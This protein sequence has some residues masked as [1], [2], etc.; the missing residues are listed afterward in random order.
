VLALPPLLAYGVALR[1]GPLYYLL[2]TVTVLGAPLLPAAVG[3]VLVLLAARL[4]P[5]RRGREVLGLVAALV[6]VSCSL[7]GQ[8]SRLW[9]ERLRE[10]GVAPQDLLNDLR[11]VAALP[12][13]SFVAG[14]GLAAAGVGDW[15]T[16]L[17]DVAGFLLVTFGLFAVCVW[18]ADTMYATG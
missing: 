2:A 12:I 10:A 8:T 4:A 6:G 3:A 15:A 9:T 16:A 11:H 1:Y 17:A 14:R 13:P 18:L 7:V 5:A